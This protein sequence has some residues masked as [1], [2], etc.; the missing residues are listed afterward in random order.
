MVATEF[1]APF[2]A[3]KIAT[4]LQFR[5]RNRPGLPDAVDTA[6]GSADLKVSAVGGT[7]ININS[8]RATVQ[9]A[10]YELSGGPLN[11]P[12]PANNTGSVRTD[13]A[14]LTY[15]D[16]HDPGVYARV[17]PGLA[18]TQNEAGV[19]DFPLATWQKTAAGAIQNMVDLRAFRGSP[20]VP[21]TSTARPRNPTRGMLAYEADTDRV[22]KWTGTEWEVL[23]EDTGWVTITPNGAN[24]VAWTNNV[25]SRVRRKNGRVHLRIAVTRLSAYGDLNLSDADGSV[26][27]TLAAEFRPTV[28][29]IG[30]G[31]HSRSPVCV[32]AE[33]G[34]GVRLF[35]ITDPIT[36]GRTVQA[37]MSWLV[38]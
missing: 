15:D 29:E 3:S 22:I 23:N 10:L 5:K 9:A 24:A 13:F 16:S 37:S 27:F 1:A 38:G 32:R 17:L 19:W 2:A 31:F 28:E 7:A 14:V 20:V 25:V 11:L 8:G 36:K 26:V 6:Y 33:R 35:P 4:A 18:L 12:V 21:C 34:G 30:F